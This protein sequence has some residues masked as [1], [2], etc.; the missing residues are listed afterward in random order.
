MIGS[1]L[2]L[3]VPRPDIMFSTCLYARFQSNSKESHLIACKRIFHYLIDTI[4]LSLWYPS[5]LDFNLITYSDA[6]LGGCKLDRK[7]ISGTCHFLGECLISWASMKQTSVATS[8]AESEYVATGSSCAQVLWI[9]NQLLDYGIVLKNFPIFCDNT[10]AINSSK[11]PILHSR[12]KHIEITN[13]F[14]VIMCKKVIF[15]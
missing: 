13:I 5:C 7:S 8:T 2:Y 6:D 15:V 10:S 11:N 14:Y 4:G 3:I 12:T 1:L 9:K